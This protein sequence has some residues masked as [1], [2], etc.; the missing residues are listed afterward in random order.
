MGYNIGFLDSLKRCLEVTTVWVPP[1]PEY[2]GAI[3]A[4]V[5]AAEAA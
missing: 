4:A 2:V 1:E 3:G 5:A